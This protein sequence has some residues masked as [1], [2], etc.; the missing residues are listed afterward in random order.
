[1]S[2]VVYMAALL[3]GLATLLLRRPRTTPRTPLTVP[4][5]AAVFLGACCFFCSAP[6]TLGAVNRATGVP[7][8]G[9]PLTYSV[10]SAYS[11]S[12][13]ILLIHWRG[14]PREQ[15][16]RMVTISVA[17]YAVLI[18]AIIALFSL[19]HADVERLRDLDTYY[20]T[21]PF[22]REMIILYLL[23]H[24]ASIIVLSMVCLRWIR[25]EVTGLLR[26]GLWLILAGLLLDVLGFEL[27]KATAVVARWSGNDL[28]FLSTKVAPPAASLGALVCSAGFVLPRLASAAASQR[29]SLTDYRALQPLWTAVKDVAT[30]PKAEP[31]WWHLRWRLPSSRLYQLEANI[32][33]GLLQLTAYLDQRVGQTAFEAA[34]E[35]G[36]SAESART[37][38]ESAMIIDGIRRVS[39]KEN[40]PADPPD[41]FRLTTDLVHL[42]NAVSRVQ[43]ASLEQVRTQ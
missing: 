12:L 4:T 25:D 2:L 27:A 18:I 36:E 37:A 26:T 16:R 28:D 11:C 29:Q 22:M 38:S 21:T 35:R 40:G 14:G 20:A 31:T 6:A 32:R 23:G 8:F 33:D 13:I 19:A 39:G 43:G 17:V 7:N 3:F 42:A 10:I 24:L 41:K 15:I 34:M 30:V 9:A 5:R 1:M